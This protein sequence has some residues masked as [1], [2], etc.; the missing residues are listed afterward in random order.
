MKFVN[1]SLL[2]VFTILLVLPSCT[3][4]KENRSNT[5][6]VDH[7]I[8]QSTVHDLFRQAYYNAKIAEGKTQDIDECSNFSRD[9]ENY[10]V[11]LDFGEENCEGRYNINRRGSVVMII[12]KAFSESGAKITVNP[13][14]F[15]VNDYKV[16]GNLEVSYSGRNAEENPTYKLTASELLFTVDESTSFTWS[17]NRTYELID[18]KADMNFVWDDVFAVRGS[19]NGSDR[20][21]AVYTAEIDEFLTYALNCRWPS[22]GKE[23]LN[24]ED[25]DEREINYGDSESCSNKAEIKRKKKSKSLDMR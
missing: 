15:Y 2:S 6:A 11:T 3:K 10:P 8:A 4:W 24:T 16:E 20:E 13:Q 7:T 19:A 21:D 23:N 5:P 12:D 9:G 1:L 22:A 17:L 14:N 25:R 18:G